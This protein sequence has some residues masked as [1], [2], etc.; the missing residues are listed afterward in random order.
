MATDISTSRG[1]KEAFKQASS[2][3]KKKAAEKAKS[4]KAPGKS[5]YAARRQPV[6]AG[7]TGQRSVEAKVGARA[8][9]VVFVKGADCASSRDLIRLAGLPLDFGDADLMRRSLSGLPI[10]V[11]DCLT[12]WVE[13]SVLSETVAPASTLRRWRKEHRKTVKGSAADGALRLINVIHLAEQAFGD[14]E[15]A[16]RWLEKPKKNLDPERPG[17][18]PW[19][20][21]ES[22]Y[23]ARIVEGRLHQIAHGTYV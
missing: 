7:Q 1:A 16:K 11:I 8:E 9:P 22:E 6:R 10:V 17:I 23:G 2:A 21:M 19:E 18:S 4:Q 5:A 14:A 20:L 12:N 15:K 13:P 3:S